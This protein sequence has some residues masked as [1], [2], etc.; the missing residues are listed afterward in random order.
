MN[1]GFYTSYF[2]DGRATTLEEQA[3][4]PIQ[5]DIE[6]NQ[7]LDEL[8]KELNDVPGYVNQFQ[9]VFGS[10]PNREDIGKALA[11]YQRTLVTEPSPFD[12]YLL[13]DEKALSADAK[14]GLELFVGEARC[15]DCHNGPML[16]DGKYYRM[17]ISQEDFGREAVTGKKEDRY[18]FRTASLR[19]VADTGPYMH[20]GLSHSLESIVLFYYR[21]TSPTTRD[22][23]PIDAPDLR[24]QSLSEVPYLVAFLQSLS[25]KAPD[26]TPPTLPLGPT[27]SE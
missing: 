8:E 21:G 17:G 19:N 20:N 26:F 23:L 25:G 12:R 4:G 18:K 22:G 7:N 10:K 2:W 1:V 11:A 13:G 3:L 16:S 14:R 5:S 9:A 24:G 27:D 6:M 15:I